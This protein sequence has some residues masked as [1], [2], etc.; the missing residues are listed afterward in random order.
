MFAECLTLLS[1]ESWVGLGWGWV[2]IWVVFTSFETDL[3]FWRF[4]FLEKMIFGLVKLCNTARGAGWWWWVCSRGV[5]V[6]VGAY[7]TI[8]IPTGAYL[9][10]CVG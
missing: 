4:I 5:V 8:D 3:A 9:V 6:A 1:W 2:C 10:G 7:G